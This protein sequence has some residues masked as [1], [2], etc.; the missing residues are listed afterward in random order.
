M[1]SIDEFTQIDLRVGQIEACDP[2]P[3]ADKLLKL[4][5][6]LGS[7][8]RQMVAGVAEEYQPDELTDKRVVVVANL[9]PATL[10]GVVSE[11]M[12][13]AAVDADGRASVVWAPED[14]P[15]GSRVR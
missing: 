15:L 9:Q 6:N 11:G 3:G 2:I 12:I 10:R 1:I 14:V 13:L 8:I 4:Q 7:E 5:V